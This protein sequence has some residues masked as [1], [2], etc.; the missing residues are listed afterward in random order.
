MSQSVT[1]NTYHYDNITTLTHTYT[2]NY[3]YMLHVLKEAY[4]ENVRNFPSKKKNFK[5][6]I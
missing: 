3:M 6:G 4:S 1:Q 2:A 5:H